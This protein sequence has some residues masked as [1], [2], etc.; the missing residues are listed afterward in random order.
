M[1]FIVDEYDVRVGALVRIRQDFLT[2]IELN[3]K[4]AGQ[5]IDRAPELSMI[6]YMRD[7]VPC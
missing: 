7:M 2:G 6:S 5:A 4:I 1:E 3:G